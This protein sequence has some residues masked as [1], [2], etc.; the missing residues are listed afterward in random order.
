MQALPPSNLQQRGR[1]GSLSQ[2]SCL[3]CT[4]ET[5]LK[6][7]K[8]VTAPLVEVSPNRAIRANRLIPARMAFFGQDGEVQGLPFSLESQAMILPQT[9]RVGHL[10]RADGKT[11]LGLRM[12]IR[13]A[14]QR[15]RKRGDKRTDLLQLHT[16]RLGLANIGGWLPNSSRGSSCPFKLSS[17]FVLTLVRKVRESSGKAPVNS[18]DN[19][20]EAGSFPQM[21]MLPGMSAPFQ[22]FCLSGRYWGGMVLSVLP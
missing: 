22:G 21:I 5:G 3:A 14:W 13:T 10:S 6:W 7:A 12:P 18:N 16:L 9:D 4:S 19:V 15:L 2:A 17:L 20:T 8:L 11:R 1:Q